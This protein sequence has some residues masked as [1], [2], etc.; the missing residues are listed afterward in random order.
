M[1]EVKEEKSYARFELMT[2]Y[3]YHQDNEAVSKALYNVNFDAMDKEPAIV[4]DVFR[5]IAEGKD[6]TI[7]EAREKDVYW[8]SRT[9]AISCGKEEYLVKTIHSVDENYRDE[10]SASI[11]VSAPQKELDVFTKK[12]KNVFEQN[13]V[14]GVDVITE[15]KNVS[16]GYLKSKFDSDKHVLTTG[17]QADNAGKIIGIYEESWL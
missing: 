13:H 5:T 7:T 17:E 9:I 16:K 8:D 4:Q 3:H 15:S 10:Y 2:S 1:K 12:I 11:I 6:G 14:H